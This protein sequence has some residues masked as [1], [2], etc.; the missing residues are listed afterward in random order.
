M[1]ESDASIDIDLDQR[2]DV[3]KE[4]NYF[5]ILRLRVGLFLCLRCGKRFVATRNLTST[6]YAIER[7]IFVFFE[8]IRECH[9]KDPSDWDSNINLKLPFGPFPQYCYWDRVLYP[10]EEALIRRKDWETYFVGDYWVDCGS[11]PD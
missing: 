6:K 7:D 4:L 1:S 2:T 3:Y 8:Y 10:W 11:I 5:D 9:P